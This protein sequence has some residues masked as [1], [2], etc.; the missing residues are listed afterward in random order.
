MGNTPCC[1]LEISGSNPGLVLFPLVGLSCQYYIKK[2]PWKTNFQSVVSFLDGVP[3]FPFFYFL[4]IFYS[5]FFFPFFLFN[6]FLN[7]FSF[8]FFIFFFFLFSFILFS[9]F[10]FYFL[11][12]LSLIF[13]FFSFFDDVI[14][15]PSPLSFLPSPTY[16]SLFFLALP[17]PPLPSFFLLP[18]RPFSNPCRKFPKIFRRS[19]SVTSASENWVYMVP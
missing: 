4:F 18:C 6:F 13:N 19:S 8:S 7:F 12:F 11:F 9:F 15:H 14:T 5:F 1:G 17:H 16:P 10:I 2:P 3:F